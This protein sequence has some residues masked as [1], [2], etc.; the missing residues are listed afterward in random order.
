[1]HIARLNSDTL[2]RFGRGYPRPQLRRQ[3]WYS[4]NGEWSFAIDRTAQWRAPDEVEWNGQ[5]V[6]PFSPET[7]ASGV[8]DTGLYRACWY[9][10]EIRFREVPADQRLVLHFGAVDYTATVWVNGTWVGE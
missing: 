8:G 1:M 5:I 9:R 7:R 3:E 2:D 4:L 10:R 6:V